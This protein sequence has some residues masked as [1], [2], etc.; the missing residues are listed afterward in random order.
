MWTVLAIPFILAIF[1]ALL[2]V[3]HLWQGRVQ[4]DGAMQA[5]ALASVQE[6]AERG[7][8]AQQVAAAESLGKEYAL[9][10][11]IHGVPVDLDDQAIVPAVA[12]AFGTGTR[13]GTGFDFTANRNAGADLTVVLQAT[14][15]VP[16]L[17]PP[18]FG[19]WIA[20][21]TVS[22]RTAAYYDRSVRP[23]RPRLILLNN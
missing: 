1:C 19:R 23:P 12:W 5:A 15:R 6:W 21:P 13:R 22:V 11:T 8:T 14:V 3:K 7:G 16:A 17:F 4:L 18:I 2:E 10:N 20:D 9:A